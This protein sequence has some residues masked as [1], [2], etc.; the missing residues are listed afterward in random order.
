MINEPS[1][2]EEGLSNKGSG[3][4]W[5]MGWK[6]V[7]TNNYSGIATIYFISTISTDYGLPQGSLSMEQYFSHSS[8]R[9]LDPWSV[10]LLLRSAPL[11]RRGLSL[12]RLLV[13]AETG[14]WIV[15]VGLEAP[16]RVLELVPLLPGVRLRTRSERDPRLNQARRL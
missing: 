13:L 16:A 11:P 6:H 1:V 2:A 12:L 4:I 7:V 3:V 10:L 9:K 5:H 15:E 8:C 14:V